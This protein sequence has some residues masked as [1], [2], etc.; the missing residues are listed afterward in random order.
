MMYGPTDFGVLDDFG[1]RQTTI[2]PLKPGVKL[3]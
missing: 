3:R 1:N 2:E